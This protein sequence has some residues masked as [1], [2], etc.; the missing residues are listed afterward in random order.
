MNPYDEFVAQMKAKQRAGANYT[1]DI[2]EKGAALA[3]YFV[4]KYGSDNAKMLCT[5]IGAASLRSFSLEDLKG[6][7]DKIMLFNGMKR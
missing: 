7:G 5:K 3:K 2:A 6:I 4:G 1:R